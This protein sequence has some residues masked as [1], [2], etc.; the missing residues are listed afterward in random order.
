[1]QYN[2]ISDIW[3]PRWHDRKVLM[4]DFEVVRHD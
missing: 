2:Y 1:M 3:Q 4:N